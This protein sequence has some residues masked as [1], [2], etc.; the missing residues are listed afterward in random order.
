MRRPDPDRQESLARVRSMRHQATEPEKRLWSK[1]RNRQVGN[2]KFRRQ[3]WI[4]PFIADFFSA[5]A[6]LLVEVDGDTHADTEA[7]DQR[8]SA[9]LSSEGYRVL[10]FSNA[11]VMENIE[12]VV[13]AILADIRSRPSPSQ[14]SGLG[15]SLSPEGRGV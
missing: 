10:R 5:E 2:L 1:L 11:D 9:W 6:R 15:P 13:E 7:Q 12:G 8:R 4:G 3:V 14:V